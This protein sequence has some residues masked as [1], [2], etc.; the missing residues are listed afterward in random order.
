VPNHVLW[1]CLE[2]FFSCVWRA[3]LFEGYSIRCIIRWERRC[4]T[5]FWL[6]QARA[7]AWKKLT[8]ES[9]IRTGYEEDQLTLKSNRL[10]MHIHIGNFGKAKPP[11]YIN[12]ATP[13]NKP[14]PTFLRWLNSRRPEHHGYGRR[15]SQRR[16][17]HGQLH[18]L[19]PLPLPCVI[20]PPSSPPL[21][22]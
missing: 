10:T 16:R 19:L 4:V 3:G 8:R 17:H 11:I 1:M 9:N 6:E 12:S 15:S 18:L 13:P 22:W 5:L 21:A 20:K 14:Q 7:L 2:L